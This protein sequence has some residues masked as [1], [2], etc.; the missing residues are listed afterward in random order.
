MCLSR[1]SIQLTYCILKLPRGSVH[2]DL[3]DRT[4]IVLALPSCTSYYVVPF[5]SGLNYA[6]ELL[7]GISVT[8]AI[9]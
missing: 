6:L 4:R 9:S 7:N 5:L 8:L 3:R 1:E 2:T